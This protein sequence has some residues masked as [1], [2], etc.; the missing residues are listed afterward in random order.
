[1]RYTHGPPD[2][3]PSAQRASRSDFR[4]KNDTLENGTDSAP[5]RP[6]LLPIGVS[7][8]A[9]VRPGRRVRVGHT[10]GPS[11][12]SPS[13]RRLSG[14]S[15][16]QRQK[17]QKRACGGP[18]WPAAGPNRRQRSGP[19]RL[20]HRVRVRHT[21]G[22]PDASPSS[23]RA[24]WSDFRAKN[25]TLENGTDSAPSAPRCSQSVSAHQ[26]RCVLD[27]GYAWATR[28]DPQPPRRVPGAYRSLSGQSFWQR[29]KDQ[30]DDNLPE[31]VAWLR[32]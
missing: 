1:M 17:D 12:A 20:G 23:Q 6:S 10:H 19:I 9:P 26:S 25:D 5:S 7:A 18:Q 29:Q 21:H 14:Q 31:T 11:A 22:P 4:A 30:I 15:F 3:S 32:S 24:S 27:A 13:A 16:W 2:A 8:A 28:T